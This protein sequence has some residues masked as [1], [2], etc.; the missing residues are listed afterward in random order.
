MPFYEVRV[1]GAIGPVVSLALSGF[2]TIADNASTTVLTGTAVDAQ[3]LA[4]LFT[5]LN[6]HGFS[7]V[8]V[9]IAP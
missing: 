5:V 6:A 1:N 7:P 8:E 9:V 4:A 2:T 3:G